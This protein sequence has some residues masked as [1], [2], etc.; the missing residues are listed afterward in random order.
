VRQAGSSESQL[1]KYFGGKD[2]LLE[3]I[4]TQF[5]QKITWR[6]RQALA[7]QALT[8]GKLI[9][10]ME[11]MLSELEADA[12]LKVLTLV[13]GRRLRKDGRMA[14]LDPGFLEFVRLLDNAL[15]EMRDL[16]ELRS[17]VNLEGARSALMGAVEGLLRDQLLAQRDGYR[18]RYNA[19][20]LRETFQDVVMCFL[21]PKSASR[22]RKEAELSLRERSRGR[23]RQSSR[24]RAS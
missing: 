6:A 21:T 1:V 23:L 2:G 22:L 13:E 15:Q 17:G 19:N 8:S 5:W 20:E 9:A 18:A 14:L 7:E 11:A 4:F 16:G 12:D 3:A 24:R 10:L